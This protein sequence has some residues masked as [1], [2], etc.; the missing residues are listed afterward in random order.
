M[1]IYSK[2][3][4]P[5]LLDF[6]MSRPNMT[7]QRERALADAHGDVLEVGFGTGLNLEHYPAKVDRLTIVDPEHLLLRKVQ[8]RIDATPIPVDIHYLD[9]CQLPFDAGRFDTV[10][11]TWTLC[12]IPDIESAL[13]EVK[14][15][16]KPG[17]RFLFVEHG[18]SD[19]PKVARRQDRWNPLQRIIG[20]GCNLNRPIGQLIERAGFEMLH[21]ER[22]LMPKEP[23]IV[24]EHYLGQATPA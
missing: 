14:R 13:G 18:R 22:F 12:T 6:V 19:D 17:G 4:F 10:V 2:Y 1:G 15:V 11:S 24:A 16:L 9:A 21:L 5:H 20:V 23:R 7:E 8:R 3:V